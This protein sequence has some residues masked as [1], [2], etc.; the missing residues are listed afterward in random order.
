[1]TEL[2]RITISNDDPSDRTYKYLGILLDEH[3]CF[4][5]HI[6]Y[7]SA[8]ISRSL[9]FI[10]KVKNV[11]PKKALLNL[12]HALIHP[13][14]LYCSNIYSCTGLSNIRKLE[15]M[16]KRA[17]RINLKKANSPTR[18]LFFYSGILPLKDLITYSKASFMHSVFNK[19][20]PPTFL[21][22]F[23]LAPPTNHVLR[24]L[25]NFLILS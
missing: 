17:V 20:C 4:D 25:N 14:F 3:L 16:Q 6:T 8:K 18:E 13:H 21:E 7:L 15:I 11:L 2:G 1:V 12:Y 9:Y 23:A 22:T 10:S 5:Q 24:N 19:Y